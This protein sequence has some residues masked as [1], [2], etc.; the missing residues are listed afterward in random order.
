MSTLGEA[1]PLTLGASC[2]I[3]TFRVRSEDREEEGT[4]D[5]AGDD[6]ILP[7]DVED[8]E[9]WT[10]TSISP[11]AEPEPEVKGGPDGG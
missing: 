4:E 3:E 11:G 1:A 10:S 5:E 9:I 7:F 2:D 6:E 8:G